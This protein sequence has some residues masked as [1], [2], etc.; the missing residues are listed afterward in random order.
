MKFQIFRSKDNQ[1]YFLLKARNGEVIATS[2][3]YKTKQACKK[4][5]RS[6]KLNAI[7]ARVEDLT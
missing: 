7:I 4:G 1:Y 3:T 5:I 6:V 2:E